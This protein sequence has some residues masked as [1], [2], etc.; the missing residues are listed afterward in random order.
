MAT[1]GAST[2]A[3]GSI[4][5]SIRLTRNCTIACGDWRELALAGIAALDAGA[6]PDADFI[7]PATAAELASDQHPLRQKRFDFV[8]GLRPDKGG[9]F[10]VTD[11]LALW[12]HGARIVL[13]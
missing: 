5:K 1:R 11:Q 12:F 4:P 3:C 2:A 13:V 10:A 9:K 8:V 7:V 6:P